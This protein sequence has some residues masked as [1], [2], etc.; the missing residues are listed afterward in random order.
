MPAR[1]VDLIREPGELDEVVCGL[2]TG[3]GARVDLVRVA[4]VIDGLDILRELDAVAVLDYLGG[5]DVE[6]SA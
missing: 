5:H 6:L 4:E 2:D 1:Q 3:I